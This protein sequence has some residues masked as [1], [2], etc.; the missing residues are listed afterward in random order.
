MSEAAYEPEYLRGIR[1]FNAG[2]FFEA[3]EAWEEIWKRTQGE[4]R[5]FYKGLI[6]AAVALYHLRN[7]NRH[8]AAKVF[9]SCRMYLGPY[10]T[11]YEGVGVARLLESLGHC[12]AGIEQ[13]SAAS[14]AAELDPECMPRIE[15]DSGGRSA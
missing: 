2:E 6:H 12:F 15:L 14:S 9:G 3:H 7:G 13:G 4:R 5:L 11:F 10:A 8:G 1:H